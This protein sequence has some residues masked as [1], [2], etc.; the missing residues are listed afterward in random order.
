MFKRQFGALFVYLLFA[1]AAWAALPP[2]EEKGG[3][4]TI[5]TCEVDDPWV[6]E[7]PWPHSATIPAQCPGWD[8][9]G[10]FAS[11]VR[12]TFSQCTYEAFG[13]FAD[14]AK[15]HFTEYFQG[16]Q[17]SGNEWD[18][19]FAI[20]TNFP[21]EKEFWQ[22]VTAFESAGGDLRQ[23]FSNFRGFGPYTA[24]IRKL[25]QD[26]GKMAQVA[27]K[28]MTIQFMLFRCTTKAVIENSPFPS[29]IREQWMNFVDSMAPFGDALMAVDSLEQAFGASAWKEFAINS[30]V[31]GAVVAE[32]TSKW[33]TM[34]SFWDSWDMHQNRFVQ[35]RN[36][37]M[38][39]LVQEHAVNQCDPK[40]ARL[41][42][43]S[44]EYEAKKFLRELRTFHS[45][46]EQS[47][48]C[49]VMGHLPMNWPPNKPPTR[50]AFTAAQV[51]AHKTSWGDKKLTFLGTAL[52][53]TN[54]TQCKTAKTMADFRKRWEGKYE[55]VVAEWEERRAT[56]EGEFKELTD[57][58]TEATKFCREEEADETF[59]KMEA[60]AKE[61][62][63]NTLNPDDWK[64]II[65]GGPTSEEY[66]TYETLENFEQT[67]TEQ[68]IKDARKALAAFKRYGETANLRCWVKEIIEQE[69]PEERIDKFEA[70]F[71]RAQAF[72][73]ELPN[74]A[75]LETQLK[76]ECS[77][78]AVV[79]SIKDKQ[80]EFSSL[81][82]PASCL[83]VDKGFG[84]AVANWGTNAEQQLA[85]SYKKVQEKSLQLVSA[86]KSE[87]KGGQAKLDGAHQFMRHQKGCNLLQEAKEK[88]ENAL[89]LKNEL[90]YCQDRELEEVETLRQR[91]TEIAAQTA[92]LLGDRSWYQEQIA[93][94]KTR[95]EQCKPDDALSILSF[96]E[97]SQCGASPSEFPEIA[98]LKQQAEQL[99]NELKQFIASATAAHNAFLSAKG[100]CSGQAMEGALAQYSPHECAEKIE[101]EPAASQIADIRK[102]RQLSLASFD[103]RLKD[104]DHS[105]DE[106]ERALDAC[107]P[108][109]AGE[110]LAKADDGISYVSAIEVS[111]LEPFSANVRRGAVAA[112]LAEHRAREAGEESNF[113]AEIQTAK[114]QLNACDPKDAL[115]TLKGLEGVGDYVYHCFNERVAEGGVAGLIDR[116]TRIERL[117]ARNEVLARE[118][119][120]EAKPFIEQCSYEY[121]FSTLD[122]VK[123]KYGKSGR[124]L[125]HAPSEFTSTYD[126]AEQ[127]KQG[128]EKALYDSSQ[129]I[130]KADAKETACKL[131]SATDLIDNAAVILLPYKHCG[132]RAPELGL[133]DKVRAR[134]EKKEQALAPKKTE[135]EQKLKLAEQQLEGCEP[136]KARESLSR[137]IALK[138]ELEL[139]EQDTSNLDRVAFVE[140]KINDGGATSYAEKK[141]A[142]R[143]KLAALT[144]SITQAAQSARARARKPDYSYQDRKAIQKDVLGLKMNARKIELEAVPEKCMRDI[145]SE[146]ESARA[147]IDAILIPHLDNRDGA[148]QVATR[149]APEPEM[150][151]EPEEPEPEGVVRRDPEPEP[152]IEIPSGDADDDTDI[153]LGD[154]MAD[155][156]AATQAG[157]SHVASLPDAPS[158]VGGMPNA[159]TAPRPSGQSAADVMR[160]ATDRVRAGRRRQGLP[161][162]YATNPR[163]PSP[164]PTGYGRG[165]GTARPTGSSGGTTTAR[166]TEQCRK[167]REMVKSNKA[168]QRAIMREKGLS[169]N[170]PQM[171]LLFEKWDAQ[172]EM[173]CNMEATGRTNI[174]GVLQE[175]FDAT[176]K[177]VRSGQVTVPGMSMDD[178]N[179]AQEIWRGGGR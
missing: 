168:Q 44:F 179:R 60:L 34:R 4:L 125:K 170:D 101:S 112:K 144:G 105:L 132:E 97:V 83:T 171:K 36:A 39:Q 141:S 66:A 113:A 128:L 158:A 103:E 108:T 104:T 40:H 45:E 42:R 74:L 17:V 149:P 100:Q 85:E 174:P 160:D 47:Y 72:V 111:C 117:L 107:E 46:V 29:S 61:P 162:P 109:Y 89:T 55:P 167:C 59:A 63:G 121:A 8:F 68:S 131:L 92:P 172:C 155:A 43:D 95:I 146:I 116:A 115:V 94:A 77:L 67:C 56:I 58:Y 96:E 133:I 18:D 71:K 22:A 142:L 150:E 163:T 138:Q 73:Q 1:Q 5:A 119:V 52:S 86:L 35:N 147:K 81:D 70:Q 10:S 130:A 99:S 20:F 23:V 127:K 9:W 84:E 33:N 62:C 98:Q 137:V 19:F 13:G 14:I 102:W 169:E 49:G 118:A 157:G 90:G 93:K 120:R 78:D 173:A 37:D 48:M 135:A 25:I 177:A 26:G 139:C 30:A 27:F 21:A 7:I 106:A 32:W 12:S 126:E 53:W 31:S 57:K 41:L 88:A 6:N 134:I 152:P 176:D 11:T 148:T 114:S 136:D 79:Q 124:C 143:G 122:R 110:M 145:Q 123:A 178:Y 154:I 28:S 3:T 24:N 16:R 156:D 15:K 159:P 166:S 50:Q 153:D 151:T 140:G 69:K 82:L 175:D 161:D 164:R 65:G 87:V 165:S 75:A 129:Y 76:Q 91:A 51:E 80:S 64:R 38:E 2:L 54:E